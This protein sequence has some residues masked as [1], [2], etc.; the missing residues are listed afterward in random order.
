M[1]LKTH[2][3]IAAWRSEENGRIMKILSMLVDTQDF[4]T[5]GV[6]VGMELGE[7]AAVLSKN[8]LLAPFSLWIQEGHDLG[9][10]VYIMK[11]KV[12]K[13][14]PFFAAF[15]ELKTDAIVAY[16][17]PTEDTTLFKWIGEDVAKV[18]SILHMLVNKIEWVQFGMFIGMSRDQALA[19]TSHGDL[20]ATF[21]S[22]IDG[23]MK[24]KEFV[25]FMKVN[26]GECFCM[27]SDC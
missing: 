25:T 27:I 21:S 4:S 9:E 10:L 12:K 23:G 18:I 6:G 20:M 15:P 17:R 1:S 8:A 5:F 11:Y 14:A 22:R 24:L 2:T 16:Q 19:V 7:A 13:S 3:Q 26:L